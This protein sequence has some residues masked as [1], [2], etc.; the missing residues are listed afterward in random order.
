MAYQMATGLYSCDICDFEMTWDRNDDIHGSMWACEKCES[1]FCSKCFI[2]RHGADAF[3][4]CMWGSGWMR[5]RGCCGRETR[6][7]ALPAGRMQN[8]KENAC[9]QLGR[10][11]VCLSGI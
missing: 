11:P 10:Q 2:D 8:D 4:S 5:S 9:N 6:F 7:F 1:H 3:Q